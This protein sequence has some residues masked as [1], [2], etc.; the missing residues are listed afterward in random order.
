MRVNHVVCATWTLRIVPGPKHDL[1]LARIRR[2]LIKGV[3]FHRSAILPR[4]KAHVVFR[5]K[6]CGDASQ[7]LQGQSL[8]DAAIATW[9]LWSVSVRRSG[10]GIDGR[11]RAKGA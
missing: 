3:I 5:H 10:S 11:P 4:W 1:Q 9:D 8:A 7:F 6:Q 2:K